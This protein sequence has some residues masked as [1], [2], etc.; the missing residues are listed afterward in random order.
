MEAVMVINMF[1][2]FMLIV[3]VLVS[4]GARTYFR[5]KFDPSEHIAQINKAVQRQEI[6]K[7]KL[8][9]VQH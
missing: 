8:H 4:G 2:A 1:T 9:N 5:R 6:A 7:R 3:I